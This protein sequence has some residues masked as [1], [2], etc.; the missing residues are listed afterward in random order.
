MVEFEEVMIQIR[1]ANK[2]KTHRA[3]SSRQMSY[4]VIERTCVEELK[5]SWTPSDH[6]INYDFSDHASPPLG[7]CE[8]DWGWEEGSATITDT[9]LV[10]EEVKGTPYS[11][12]L[13]PATDRLPFASAWNIDVFTIVMSRRSKGTVFLSN[14]HK[15]IVD[16]RIAEQQEEQRERA[17]LSALRRPDEKAQ[18]DARIRERRAKK[19]REEQENA[20]RAKLA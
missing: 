7:Q 6:E 8:L 17:R 15:K 4:N 1:R 2:W 11:V 16:N 10:V 5:L 12:I 13:G 9:F 19:K 14:V 18:D 20:Q 3:F